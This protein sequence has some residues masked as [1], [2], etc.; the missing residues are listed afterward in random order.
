[1]AYFDNHP[2][3]FRLFFSLLASAL[4]LLASVAVYRVASTPTDENLFTNPPSNIYVTQSVPGTTDTMSVGDLLVSVNGK[5]ING[6]DGLNKALNEAESAPV[7]VEVHRPTRTRRVT[8]AIDPDR[9]RGAFFRR[10]DPTAMV[11]AVTHGGASDRAGMH[12]GDFIMTIN[13]QRFKNSLDADRIMREGQVGKAIAYEVLRNNEVVTLHVALATF[14]MPIASFAMTVSGLL[15]FFSGVFFGLVRPRFAAARL[16]GLAYLSIGFFAMVILNSRGGLATGTF[17]T[18]RNGALLL[19]FFL[20]FPFSFHSSHYFPK[21]RPELIERRWI[22]IT[23]YLL[24]GLCLA[25]VAILGTPGFFIGIVGMSAYLGI[26]SFVFRKKASPEY[27][28]MNRAM[29]YASLFTAIGSFLF[30]MSVLFLNQG[31]NAGFIGLFVVAIPLAQWYTVGRYR[32]LDLNLRV[33][34]NVQYIIVT[35]LWGILLAALA[36]QILMMFQGM[37]LPIP[38]IH[39]SATSIEVLESP[40]SHE[41]QIWYE[42]GILMLLAVVTA[43][44]A[45]RVARG[46]QTVIDKKFYRARYDYRRAA[47]ELSEMMATKLTMV[48]L[49]RGMVEKIADLMQLKRVGVLFFR[50]QKVCCC[51]EAHGFDGAEWRAFCLRK[52]AGI[53]EAIREFKGVFSVDYLPPEIK[54]E[55]QGQEF[56]HVVPIRSK[57]QLVGALLVGE[58]R[59]EATFHNEDLAFLSSAAHQASV[60]VENA[61]LYEELAQQERM[62]HEL[63]IARQIQMASL[64]QQ[65]PKIEGLDI[66][67]SSVPALEVGGDYFDYLN[68]DPKK[69]TVI[70]GDVSGKGTS[71]ALY[72]SKVQGILRSLHQFGLSPKELFVR[73]NKLLCQDMEKKSFVTAIVGFFTPGEKQLILARAGHLPL[74]YYDAEKAV[75]ERITPKGLGLGLEA[76]HLFSSELEERVVRYHPNDIFL[77]VSD[78]ITEAEG[79]NGGQFGEESLMEHLRASAGRPA[80][81]ILNSLLAAVHSFANGKEQHD[82]QTV[83]VV[84]A[85]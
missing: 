52:E 24:A 44:G 10:L 60:A 83:V 37:K 7:K 20:A 81:E 74:Y 28:H 9:L 61:F 39:F 82:D 35:A 26:V 71:A 67:G 15:I 62:K 50:D 30:G 49:A 41:Q 17:D 66:A 73:T 3:Q 42:K 80:E 19:T 12:V 5:F 21:E 78:G 25:V 6:P 68:G 69:L 55:F 11:I 65:T 51:Q 27:K 1:M 54:A 2:N 70:V 48:D 43:S 56:H 76:A 34:R 77:F 59:S 13:G 79:E 18:I 38:N 14:G 47:T 53:A 57:D 45:W 58:K 4:F 72:M 85:L 40:L 75:V 22:R 23:A 31:Q 16:S 63:A 64:P 36:I 8:M 29:R 32:L 33:R 46:G 84:K